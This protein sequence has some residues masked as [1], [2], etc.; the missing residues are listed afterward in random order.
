MHAAAYVMTRSGDDP[1]IA[2]ASPDVEV[3]QL[4]EIQNRAG[5]VPFT[6]VSQILF[7]FVEVS[8]AIYG[9][10]REVPSSRY[11]LA[12]KIH[13]GTLNSTIVSISSAMAAGEY[14]LAVWQVRTMEGVRIL[15]LMPDFLEERD[16]VTITNSYGVMTD[17]LTRVSAGFYP[18]DELARFG[19]EPVYAG[20]DAPAPAPAV[21]PA[22]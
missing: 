10:A 20:N 14:D 15:A 3:D 21:R 7:G 8:S 17:Q 1:H 6:E 2:I 5:G 19:V 18:V 4:L 12:E 11:E 16:V 9:S 13:E 22:P